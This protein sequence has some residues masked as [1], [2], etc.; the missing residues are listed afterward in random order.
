M[1]EAFLERRRRFAEEDREWERARTIE[2]WSAV[3]ARFSFPH[4]PV[5]IAISVRANPDGPDGVEIRVC[6][7]SVNRDTG[8]QL[9]LW[10]CHFASDVQAGATSDFDLME[11]IADMVRRAW[12][13]EIREFTCVDG[14]VFDD[15]H[16]DRNAHGS[17]R[18]R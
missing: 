8:E 1:S 2:R 10:Q 18:F 6:L 16:D 5:P 12:D 7:S 11:I 14:K 4:C 13:H 9:K 3:A 17:R 15:P